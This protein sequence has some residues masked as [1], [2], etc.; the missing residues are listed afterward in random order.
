M[1][2]EREKCSKFQ[3]IL[4]YFVKNTS[5]DLLIFSFVFFIII[6]Y[7]Y[8]TVLSCV[9]GLQIRVCIG[10]LF[11]LFLIQN[12]C[13]GYSKESSQW[14]GSFEHP[15]HMFKLI[16]KEIITILPSWNFLIWIY[17]ILFV[18]MLYASVNNFSVML[19]TFLGLTST[20]QRIKFLPYGQ[21]I[22][23]PVRLKPAAPQSQVEH[24]TTKS[25]HSSLYHCN[26]AV[27]CD[28]TIPWNSR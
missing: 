8:S 17:G 1:R 22:L 6:D 4:P 9:S 19:G 12:I 16:G 7:S 20:K 28:R 18:L 21:N 13:C 27:I 24:S 10:K 14:D 2:T 5:W 25:L 26:S 3:N 23:I 11:P 15:K